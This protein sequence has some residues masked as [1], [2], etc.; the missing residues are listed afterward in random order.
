MKRIEKEIVE[1]IV[2]EKLHVIDEQ[3]EDVSNSKRG[4]S[5]CKTS[6]TKP[7]A[8]QELIP[9]Q[10]CTTEA[11]PAGWVLKKNWEMIG[12]NTKEKCCDEDAKESNEK[13]DVQLIHEHLGELR[14]TE[15]AG[16][17]TKDICPTGWE[18]KGNY[19]NIKESSKEKC[20]QTKVCSGYSPKTGK[21]AGMGKHCDH[22][23]D[24]SVP[25]CFVDED[26][27]GDLFAIRIDGKPAK[28]CVKDCLVE[29]R[30]SSSTLEVDSV[31]QDS[32]FA[33]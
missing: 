20:C 10:H 1:E 14:T 8:N 31:V 21:Y 27:A 33:Q 18:L 11:C 17:C 7:C 15:L 25:W 29:H 9:G 30:R 28:P 4:A 32:A 22:W 19:R 23:N 26:R 3:K 13:K 16:S 5:L 24:V 6:D 12:A 2:K